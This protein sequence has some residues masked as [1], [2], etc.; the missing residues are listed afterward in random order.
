MKKSSSLMFLCCFLLL[1]TS[2][3]K[4]KKIIDEIQITQGIAVDKSDE[5]N[6]RFTSFYPIHNEGDKTEYKTVSVLGDSTKEARIQLNEATQKPI[7]S[8]KLS[9]LLFSY[10]VAEN[11]INEMIDTLQRDPT[12]GRDVIVAVTKGKSGPYLINDLG[13]NQ[14]NA[15]YIYDLIKNNQEA[16]NLPT[17]DLHQFLFM[18]FSEG[19]EPILPYVILTE[20]NIRLAGLALFKKDKVKSIV[21]RDD[22]FLFRAM[23]EDFKTGS[24][25]VK[26]KDEKLMLQ[27]VASK[28][29]YDIGK[30]QVPSVKI[31]IRIKGYISEEV[32]GDL[33][34]SDQIKQYKKEM[35]K[36]IEHDCQELLAKLQEENLDSLGIGEQVRMRRRDW[37]NKEWKEMYKDVSIQVNC[38]VEI[39]HSGI[40]S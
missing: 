6:Y 22:L 26:F 13:F 20:G 16:G 30:G 25:Q 33:P 31:N 36:Q 18:Y 8:G 3:V 12:I 1:T 35:E 27:N 9:T 28:V 19:K 15:R 10:K 17:T 40:V 14:G 34:I 5:K 21:S 37:K 38:D 39:L 2:C 32:N 29:N 23:Y 4:D 7:F 24:Y 11:G